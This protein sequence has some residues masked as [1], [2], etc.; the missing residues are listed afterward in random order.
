MGSQSTPTKVIFFDLDN[1]LFDHSHSLAQAILAIKEKYS[2]NAIFKPEFLKYTYNSAL[3]QAYD[4]YLDGA[5][6]YEETDVEKVRIFFSSLRMPQPSFE[7]INEFRATYK[8]AYRQSQRATGGSSET[9]TRLREHGYKIVIITNGMIECQTN[10]VKAIG[11][12]HLVDRI[13]ASE[14]V[15]HKKPDL[16]IFQY[17]IDLFDAPLGTTVM[18]GDDAKRDIH[19]ALNAQLAPFLYAPNGQISR[20]RVPGV[21]VLS[22]MT[23]LLAHMGI[24]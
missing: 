11:L 3:N 14:E 1:T 5:I 15:G 7:E 19:G 9:L 4:Q 16:R 24:H 17:A 6:T 18:V 12:E 10:K 8:A 21:P 22:R 2:F 20:Q 23:E 13:I